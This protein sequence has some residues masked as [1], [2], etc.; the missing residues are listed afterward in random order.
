MTPRLP[1]DDPSEDD[2]GGLRRPVYP[3]PALGAYYGNGNGNGAKLMWIVI[4]AMVVGGFGLADRV[5]N[6]VDDLS[7][8]MA[9]VQNTL[10]LIVSGK[11]V[12]VKVP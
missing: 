12:I 9:A 5:L 8:K 4:G 11:I 1:P 2:Y 6:K 10:D 3:P 7:E